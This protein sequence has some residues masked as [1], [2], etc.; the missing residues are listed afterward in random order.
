[1]AVQLQPPPHTQLPLHRT[2]HQPNINQTLTKHFAKPPTKI[3][4]INHKSLK[5]AI[6][7]LPSREMDAQ[8]PK[9]DTTILHH[10][11]IDRQTH[12]KDVA[13]PSAGGWVS[14]GSVRKRDCKK[15]RGMYKMYNDVKNVQK[16]QKERSKELKRV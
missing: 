4:K 8:T 5:A 9:I 13:R 3:R 10:H 7:N 6:E 16:V 15:E 12:Q 2:K 11:P 14:T 1:V